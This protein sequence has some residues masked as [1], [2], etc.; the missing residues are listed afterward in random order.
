MMLLICACTIP[1][2]F[3]AHIKKLYG[4]KNLKNGVRFFIFKVKHAY[5]T[6]KTLAW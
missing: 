6:T 4:G 2:C 5:N 1:M 3:S